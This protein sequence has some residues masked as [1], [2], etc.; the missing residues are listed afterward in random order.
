MI[1]NETYYL[2]KDKQGTPE[3]H[4]QRKGR[5]TA[6]NLGKIMGK[7]PY[8]EKPEEIAQKILGKKKEEFSKES[9]ENM[10]L[11]NEYEPI[12]RNY[13]IKHLKN[14]ITETGLAVLKKNNIF[15]ASLD[16][17]INDD[18]GIEIK[19]PRKMYM[20]LLRYMDKPEKDR[21]KNDYSHIWESHY[22]QI[23]MNGV[24]TNRKNMIYCVYAIEDE[25][26]F[27]Q[28]VEIDYKYW[29]E[30]VAPKCIDFHKKYVEPHLTEED[31]KRIF[32]KSAIPKTAPQIHSAK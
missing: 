4:H 20:P 26:I 6:S 14:N 10:K 1:N 3:W 13:L 19:C 7:V 24:V 15:A 8:S 30:V 22:L 21:K 9:I 31:K 23:L 5:I 12:V 17:V 25:E 27:I 16:G 2:L 29:N 11:G 32:I 28:N 18:V